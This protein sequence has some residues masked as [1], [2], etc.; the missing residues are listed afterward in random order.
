MKF[1]KGKLMK[2]SLKVTGI[3]AA[4]S[5]GCYAGGDIVAPIE[6]AIEEVITTVNN[7]DYFIYGAVGRAALDVESTLAVDAT[8]TNGTFDD[9]GSVFELGAG[10]RFNDNVFS[11]IS[12]QRT[13]LDIVN[14]DNYY[15]SI[16]YQF[17]DVTA[18]PYIGVL[19]GYSRLKWSPR[20]H[21]M[22]INEKLISDDPMYGIQVGLE[23]TFIEDWSLFAK[24]Q[25]IKYDHLMDIRNNTNI[26]EHDDGQ[27]LLLGVQYGF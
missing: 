17:S 6:P 12:V 23:H 9:R 3:L 20:P 22:L 4:L 2:I 24:Y 16:N 19:L 7:N 26:I 27:N 14:I 10:Y 18:K 25:F 13:A 1:E 8:F 5:S 21:E 15:A 11:T